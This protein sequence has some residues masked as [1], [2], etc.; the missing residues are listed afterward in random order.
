MNTTEL[1]HWPHCTND[2]CTC[3]SDGS[4]LFVTSTEIETRRYPCG[5]SATGAK[6]RLM[7]HAPDYRA[8]GRYHAICETCGHDAGLVDLSDI[9]TLNG[10]GHVKARCPVIFGSNGLRCTLFEGHTT[11]HFAKGPSTEDYE[12]AMVLDH[13][14]PAFGLHAIPA[15][16]AIIAQV[17][18]AL[19]MFKESKTPEAVDIPE[20]LTRCLSALLEM[21]C[22]TCGKVKL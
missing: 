11:A 15:Q 19:R 9:E 10:H 3:G 5:A 20:L 2:P 14:N 7:P 12:A 21:V 18:W 4:V 8:R 6:P 17:E 16:G 1:V 22:V 13:K